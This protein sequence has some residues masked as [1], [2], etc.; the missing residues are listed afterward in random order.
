M[1]YPARVVL[2]LASVIIAAGG[3][4]VGASTGAKRDFSWR[5]GKALAQPAP[6]SGTLRLPSQHEPPQ[7]ASRVREAPVKPPA[8]APRKPVHVVAGNAAKPPVVAPHGPL[9]PH[10]PSASPAGKPAPP[11]A[12]AAVPAPAPIPVP[13]R[14]PAPGPQPQPSAETR[15]TVPDKLPDPEK[16]EDAAAKLPRFA[17]LRSDDV[18]MRA[19]PGTRYRIDWVYKRR[20][21]PVEI[22]R[23]FEVWRWVRDADGIQ[24][25]VHGAT[26]MGRR[27]FIVQKADATLRSQASDS[28][29]PVA[30]LK[31]GVIGRIR[32]CE[33]ASDW[34][35]VQAGSYRGFL[36]RDQFWG[37]LPNEAVAP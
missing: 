2:A 25:W 35:N 4:G 32:T 10:R 15:T 7:H 37:T 20:D 12:A 23:E 13:A 14:V 31:P 1:R 5:I 29:K 18:N 34:C 8:A 36:R 26:L 17:S 21:L 16:P 3:W 19:G 33:A 28:A 9:H 30:I 22:E 27:S 6:A 24:G 11:A